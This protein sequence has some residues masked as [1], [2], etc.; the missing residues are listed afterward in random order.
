MND[1]RSDLP[2][3]GIIRSRS[4]SGAQKRESQRIG[5]NFAAKLDRRHTPA[6]RARNTRNEDYLAARRRDPKKTIRKPT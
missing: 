6:A 4:G 5:D 2:C 3:P 1:K